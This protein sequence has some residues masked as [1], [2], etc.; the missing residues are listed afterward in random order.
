MV[1][2]QGG[3]GK[4]GTKNDKVSFCADSDAGWSGLARGSS[5]ALRFVLESSIKIRIQWMFWN[6][7]PM[8]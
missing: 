8:Q 7:Q 2:R 1:S 5:I 6:F 4:R 3:P